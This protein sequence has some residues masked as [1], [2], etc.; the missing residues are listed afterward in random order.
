MKKACEADPLSPDYA[1]YYASSFSDVDPDLYRRLSLEVVEKFPSTERGAQA[2]YWLALRTEDVEE[3]IK[4][5]NRSLTEFPPDKFGWSSSSMPYLFDIYLTSDP[6]RAVVFAQ[7]MKSLGKSDRDIKSWEERE[8]LAQSVIKVKALLS[9]NKTKEAEEA[10]AAIIIP[11]YSGTTEFIKLLQ[12]EVLFAG[13]NTEGAFDH[14]LKYFAAEPTDIIYS[15]LLS[16][17]ENLDK[18]EAAV[19]QDVKSLRYTSAVPATPFSLMAYLTNDTLSLA[20][21]KG[22]VVLLTYWFPGCGPCRGE[23]PN[24]QNVINRFKGKDVAYIGINISPEQDEYVV[25]FVKSSGYSFIPLKDEPDKRGNLTA[26]GA[27][28][29]YLLDRD[30]NIVFKNFRTDDRNERTL[31]L[32]IQSLLE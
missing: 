1:F 11:R 20:D 9:E 5:Y 28:T 13:G 2:I 23:F 14:L 27:P 31:E 7:K 32:M 8:A 16:Y 22:K 29:N 24:F 10:A 12:A 17:G 4:L 21:L 3:R 25:P 6:D 30:G 18:N 26:R 15:R 19:K